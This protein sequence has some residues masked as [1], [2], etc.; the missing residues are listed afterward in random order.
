MRRILLAVSGMSPQIITEALYCL[1]SEGRDVSAIHIITTRQGKDLLQAGLLDSGKGHLFRFCAE[2]G[3]NP[4]SIACS[5]EQIHIPQNRQ[6]KELSDIVDQDDNEALLSL[7]LRLAHELTADP[8]TAVYFL[9]AGGRKTMT[10]CLSFAAQIY[11]RAQDRIYHVLVSQ[12]F[13]N[14]PDFW[15]QPRTSRRLE[16]RDRQGRCFWMDT[17][18][19][20]VQLVSLP[21]LSLRKHLPDQ[22][23]SG[24]E[25]PGALMAQLVRE[26]ERVFRISLTEKSVSCGSL[27]VDV[28]PAWLALLALLAEIRL[29]NGEPLPPDREVCPSWFLE[30][31]EILNQQER[32][33]A[34]YAR[35]GGNVGSS[36]TGGPANLDKDAFSSYK[37]HLNRLLRESFGSLGEALAVQ[38]RG[39]RPDTR[40]GLWI[41]TD[42]LKLED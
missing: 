23:L 29:R 18:Q 34:L 8:D 14:C 36:Q 28:K 20:K 11:G 30:T 10:S 41:E 25:K 13:E 6:G 31:G 22:V 33:A 21:F 39:R 1:H 27:Q 17:S 26:E 15:F 9:V 24:P 5:R 7:C 37:S 12:E 40:F 2:Y 38:K 19:A 42:R 16:L 32:L 4:E 35:C 3:L